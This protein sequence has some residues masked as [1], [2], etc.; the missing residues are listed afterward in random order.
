MIISCAKTKAFGSI[1]ASKKI[2]RKSVTNA[3]MQIA[4]IPL[5]SGVFRLEEEEEEEIIDANNCT[6]AF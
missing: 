1:Y 4:A 5:F 6:P 3:F 2:P